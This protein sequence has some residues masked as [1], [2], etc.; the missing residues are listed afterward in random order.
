[1]K[2]IFKNRLFIILSVVMVTLVFIAC[3]KMTAY[4]NRG[5]NNSSATASGDVS[6][7]LTKGDQSVLLQKQNKSC[8][9]NNVQSLL[10]NHS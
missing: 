6:F 2:K 7:W 3:K 8:F 5:S 10:Y 9:W 4:A 1:M